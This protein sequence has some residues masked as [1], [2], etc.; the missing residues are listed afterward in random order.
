MQYLV[1]ILKVVEPVDLHCSAF[2]IHV[3]KLQNSTPASTN[4]LIK[5]LKM[6]MSSQYLLKF[7]IWFQRTLSVTEMEGVPT[8]DM[9]LRD[10]GSHEVEGSTPE[11]ELNVHLIDSNAPLLPTEMQQI[12]QLL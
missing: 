7:T 12:T 5:K 4:L 8:S 6:A 10:V 1:R 11:S 2:S 9:W 3:S